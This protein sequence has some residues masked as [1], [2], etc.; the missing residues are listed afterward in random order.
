M[1]PPQKPRKTRHDKG[2]IKATDRDI[3]LLKWV[4]DMY[5]AR[6]D[7]IE[8]LVYSNPG[9]GANPEGV[10]TSAVRQVVSRWRRA[11]W[12]EYRQLLAGEPPWVWMTHKGLVAFGFTAYRAT[13]PAISRLRHIHA[14]N[15]VRIDIEGEDD[16]W[17]S[18]RMIRAGLYSLP[19]TSEEH[20]HI[21]DAIL[22]SYDGEQ[23]IEVELTQK[24]P[25]EL[26]KKMSSLVHAYDTSTMSY[27]Y[28]RIRYFTPDKGVKKALESVRNHLLDHNQRRARLVE[29]ELVSLE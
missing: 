26:H 7:T 21:P 1:F 22:R 27:V 17:I 15:V 10:S 3:Y 6:F 18:E 11:E 4:A 16:E 25:E 12:I 20:R 5:A 2:T 24:K 13:P 23:V 9:P 29:I 19:D 14:L 8:D 28:T